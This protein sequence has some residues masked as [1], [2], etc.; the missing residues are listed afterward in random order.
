MNRSFLV[1]AIAY[2]FILLFLYTGVEKLM[3]I[4]SFRDQMVSSPLLGSVA[5]F[6][7]WA[8]P[9]TEI[10]LAV[11]LFV[12]AWRTKALFASL[13]LMVAFTI[14]LVVILIID[15]NL[16]CSCGGIIED[17]SPRQHLLF[18]GG[19]VVLAA[20]ALFCSRSQKPS[21]RFRW[22]TTSSALLAFCPI[23]WIIFTAA[24]APYKEKTGF[25]GRLLPS[26]TLLLS[27]S[28]THL[29]TADIPEG[30]SFIVVGFSPYCPHCQA[31]IIDIIHHIRQF[32][33][34]QIYF[35]TPYPYSDL[36]KFS[37]FYHLEKYPNI[38]AGVDIKNTF[39][40][41]FK[42]RAIPYVTIFDPKK[43]LKEVMPGQTDAKLLSRDLYE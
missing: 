7:A 3:E 17:L 16:T 22:L 43:R 23:A 13:V 37:T 42:A 33:D 8:L 10:V 12:P 36:K 21:L 25:E 2:F 14:Y 35:V 1:N 30:K 27:D 19:S 31:E 34:R 28:L 6:I 40:A 11:L 5:G 15:K 9:I 39:M 29:N 38:I 24:R 41:Y 26:F 4:N 20:L 32:G 18:N